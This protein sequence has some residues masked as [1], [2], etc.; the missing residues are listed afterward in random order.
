MIYGRRTSPLRSAA[1]PTDSTSSARPLPSRGGGV[2]RGD[3][4]RAHG[5]AVGGLALD[6]GAAAHAG[7]GADR[8]R[9]D[10]GGVPGGDRRSGARGRRCRRR[11]SRRHQGGL[12][13]AAQ[14]ALERHRAQPRAAARRHPRAA[15]RRAASPKSRSATAVRTGDTPARGAHRDAQAPAAHP[16]DDARVALHPAHLRGRPR[17]A[18]HGRDR[19]RRRD[20]RHGRRQAR[21]APRAHARAAGPPHRRSRRCASA[22][23]PRSGRSRRWR[24]FLF[25]ADRE[26]RDASSISAIAAG[27]DLALELPRLAARSGDVERGV[28]R[29]LR[30][31]RRAGPRASNHA[32]VR[33]H[34]AACRSGWRSTSPTA[35]A[36][37]PS[38]RTTA[39]CRAISASRPSGGS[40][41]ASCALW[42]PPRRSSSAS[43]SAAST[44]SASSAR[45]ARSP[46]C[47]SA[48]AAPA[49]RSAPLRRAGSSRSR[50]T[51]W[52]RPSRWCARS[53]AASSTAWWCPS[54]RST[55]WRSRS[56]PRWRAEDWSEHELFDLV[57]R[58]WPFRDLER[59][60]FDEVVAMLRDG[61]AGRTGRRGAYLHHDRV[62]GRLRARR[63]ARLAAIT[64]GGAIPDTADYDVVLEPG[65]LA[66]APS[67]RTSRSRAWPATSSS[68]AT[69][70]G[71]SSRSSRARCGSRTRAA[72][73]RPSRSGWARRRR[74]PRSC[75]AR[76]RICAPRCRSARRRSGGAAGSAVGRRHRLAR[77]DPRRRRGRRAPGG[78][79]PRR[80]R[81]RARRDA[82]AGGAG[83]RA[84]LRRERRHAA[85]PARAV[86]QPAQPRLG[87]RAAQALLPQVQLRA[88]GRRHRGRHRAVARRHPQLPARRGLLLPQSRDGARRAGAGAARRA[89]VGR[90]LAL[91][92]DRARWRCCA[93]AA[94]AACRRSSS[95]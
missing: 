72:R 41:P 61:F 68:S 12:R 51:S 18:A 54:G 19:D 23:R 31:H 57:R 90:A 55:S 86:R 82:D 80:L 30:P 6:Q 1:R 11:P 26:Q 10:A 45:R 34:A 79:V 95:A 52:S 78:R 40:R 62:N 16:G 43:T 21:L 37:T 64:N 50:A 32:G 75:R 15:A 2:V 67:T 17:D 42:S 76:C 84:L 7:R 20:P 46:R 53:R 8:L 58:A 48:S 81:A 92:R 71:G 5:A 85:R 59:E 35:S 87:P 25:T 70:R 69:P 63:G 9:Q 49:T 33:Q 74:A 3:P 65:E 28:G 93:S 77:L 73:R 56:S 27:I 60:T 39:R 88:A 44:W 24:D 94:G 91:E 4:R 29:D 38:P 22:S 83:A 14:G 13:L 89:G 36:R 47:C 66:S